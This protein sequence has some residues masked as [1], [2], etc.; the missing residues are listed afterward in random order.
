MKKTILVYYSNHG[1]NRFL[2]EQ[3][4]GRLK[5]DSEA[6]RPVPDVHLLLLMGLGFGNRRLK[7][8]LA[9]YDRV[10]L[11]GPIWMG[12]FI[13]PLKRFVKT[14]KKSIRELIFVTCCGSS[15]EK[16][17]EKFGHG[18]VFKELKVMLPGREVNCLALP[19]T[20][21]LTK[22]ET[23]DPKKVL[24]TRLNEDNFKGEILDRFDGFMQSLET[25]RSPTHI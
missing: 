9:S 21:T 12:K 4:A 6:L 8:D 13:H 1:S 23:E 20:L 3:V 22:E 7:H 19:I 2:A 15:Y 18:L 24:E 10:I 11:V 5:C 25:K 16:K 17:E 14:Y